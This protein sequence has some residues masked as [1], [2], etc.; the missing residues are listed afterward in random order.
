MKSRTVWM[1]SSY[2][3]AF[4]LAAGAS[5]QEWTSARPDGHAPLAV[6]G[7]HT[8]SRGEVMLSYR[9]M[10]MSMDG[11]RMDTG[12]VTPA[13]VLAD[14]MVTPLRMSMTMH[15]AGL[16]V[17]PSDRLTLMATASYVRLEMDHRTRMGG[18][19]TTTASGVGDIKV[20]GLLELFNRNR[21]ALHLNL[22]VSVPTGS[23]EMA[24]VTP[25]SAPDEAILPYP[26]QIGSGTTDLLPGVTYLGQVDH[27]SWGAQ[28]RATIRMGENDRSYRLGKREPPGSRYG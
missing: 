11:N 24:D 6:M 1:L 15:M 26:M 14:F 2:S 7:D 16:M 28:A 27:W 22:G 18:E 23:I 3:L 25:A 10:R 13:E 8:H 21:Q 20:S 19:F 9:F 17:A 12:P 4:L 5:A